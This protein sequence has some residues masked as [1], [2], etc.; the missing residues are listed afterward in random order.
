MDGRIVMVAYKPKEGMAAELKQL[1]LN[2]YTILNDQGLVT[3][4]VPILMQSGDGTILEVFE[5]KSK[6]AIT[7]AHTNPVIGAMWEQYN[8]VCDYIPAGQVAEIC[9]LFSEFTP[10]D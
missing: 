7:A 10:I 4:R 6:E 3:D 9:T 2:H 1:A 5:W 8:R